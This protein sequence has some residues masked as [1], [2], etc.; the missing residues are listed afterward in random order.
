M[1]V[2]VFA[3]DKCVQG[4]L[5]RRH[6]G[7]ISQGAAKSAFHSVFG[8]DLSMGLR[9]ERDACWLATH[10]GEREG[11]RENK[12]FSFSVGKLS[13]DVKSSSMGEKEGEKEEREPDRIIRIAGTGLPNTCKISL[14]INRT[15]AT[16]ERRRIGS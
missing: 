5:S 11:G 16:L 1:F 3:F 6:L 8:R 7:A 12:K 4:S 9:R 14:L 15:V 13:Q 2:C 10:W